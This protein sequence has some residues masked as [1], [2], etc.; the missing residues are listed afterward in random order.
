MQYIKTTANEIKLKYEGAGDFELIWEYI[1]ENRT[2]GDCYLDDSQ[3]AWFEVIDEVL[4][5]LFCITENKFLAN[6]LHMSVLEVPK[7]MRKSGYGEKIIE[8]LKNYAK[9][10]GLLSVTLQTHNPS[11]ITYYQKFGFSESKVQD[12]L[13]MRCF[14]CF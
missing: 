8:T 14:L 9:E 12:C 13:I 11:L 7:H 3:Y 6:S 1:G 2:H 10:L 5:G 4:V